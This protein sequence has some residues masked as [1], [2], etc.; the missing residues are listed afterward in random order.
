MTSTHALTLSGV[1]K[2]SFF[3]GELW[4]PNGWATTSFIMLSGLTIPLVYRWQDV[5]Y[6]SIKAKVQRRAKEILIVMFLSNTLMLLLKMTIQGNIYRA[7]DISWWLGLITFNTP[8][9]ISAILIPTGLLMCIAPYLVKF[10]GK[11]GWKLFSLTSLALV[12]FLW[13]L[14][15]G[16]S[17]SSNRLF[18]LLFTQGIGGFPV[19]PFIGLGVAGMSIGFIIAKKYVQN[20]PRGILIICLSF[21]V[22]HGVFVLLTQSDL[23]GF[24]ALSRFALLCC[25]GVLLMNIKVLGYL[26]AYFSLIGKY[27]LFSFLLHRVI[28]QTI[29]VLLSILPVVLTNEIKYLASLVTTMVLIGCFC[30][31]RRNVKWIDDSF[32]KIYL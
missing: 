10:E 16:Y 32:K 6:S 2:A 12:L 8:Y 13:S 14:K 19:M 26:K 18:Q 29:V 1:S 7:L 30:L 22:F 21:I 15:E 5:A 4:L 24:L 9:S 25:L 3:W 17:D 20:K 28:L 11:I 23:P 27:A 31:V